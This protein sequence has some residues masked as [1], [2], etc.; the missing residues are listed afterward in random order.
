MDDNIFRLKANYYNNK[1]YIHY[2]Y[3]RINNHYIRWKRIEEH[4]NFEF[5]THR[6]LE[7]LMI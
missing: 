2:Y 3:S 7:Y 4:N 5:A 1:R 6:L